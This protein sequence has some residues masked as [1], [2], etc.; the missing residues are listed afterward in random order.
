MEYR[1]EIDKCYS[2]AGIALALSLYDAENLLCGIELDAENP[3]NFTPEFNHEFMFA[4]SAKQTWNAIFAHFQIRMGLAIASILSRKMILDN[5]QVDKTIR[6]RLLDAILEEGRITCQLDEDEIEPLFDRS[7]SYLTGV[8]AR[9]SVK[10][11][12]RQMVQ[13]LQNKRTVTSGELNDMLNQ[14]NSAGV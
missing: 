3:L 2:L 8:F 5:G 11:T 14:M 6:R 13:M 12:L 9:P 10:R 1:S 4:S 7:F